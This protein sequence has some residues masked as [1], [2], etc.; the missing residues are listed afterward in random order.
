MENVEFTLLDLYWCEGDFAQI[1]KLLN[2][3]IVQCTISSWHQLQLL[4]QL[5]FN[6]KYSEN[7]D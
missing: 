6:N 5:L 1:G 3:D 7:K 2:A 4:G